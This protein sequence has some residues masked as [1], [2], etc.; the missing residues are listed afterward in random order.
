MRLF[1]LTHTYLKTLAIVRGTRI[2]EFLVMIR[3]GLL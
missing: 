2:G 3:Q 1:G